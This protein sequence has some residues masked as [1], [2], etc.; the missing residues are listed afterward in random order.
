MS[1]L[2]KWFNK[3][4]G[5]ILRRTYAWESDTVIGTISRSKSVL[6]AIMSF[7]DEAFTITG[8]RAG[9]LKDQ[10]AEELSAYNNEMVTVHALFTG[11]EIQ[12]PRGNVGGVCDPS[13]ESHHCM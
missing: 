3:N 7:K 12:I 1:V 2:I 8:K 9:E 4:E 10:I 13:T 5:H 6:T 11:K